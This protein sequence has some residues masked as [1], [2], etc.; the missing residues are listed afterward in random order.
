MAK[1]IFSKDEARNA[2]QAGVNKVAEPVGSTM[3]AGGKTVIISNHYNRDPMVTKD[4]V[5]VA[6]CIILP[7]LKENVG[8]R[9]MRKA[10]ES[11]AKEAGDGT[12]QTI[13]LAQS[14]INNGLELIKQGKSP[15]K[16][17]SGINKGVDCIVETLKKISIP[18]KD[19]ETIRNIATISAN[20]DKKIGDL[21]AKGYDKIGHDGIMVIENSPTS[22]TKIEVIEGVEIPRGYVSPDFVNDNAKQRVVHENPIYIIAD[23]SISNMN[24]LAPILKQLFE[25]ELLAQ[26]IIIIATDFEGEAF[27]SVLQNHRQGIVKA[28]LVKA[29]FAYR[30]EYLE[31][32]AIVTGA[33][34]I[35]DE[36]GLKME[37]MTIEHLGRSEKVIITE[38]STTIIGGL[39]DKK[40][41]DAQKNTIRVQMEAYADQNTDES[42]RLKQDW[43][44]RLGR[45]SSSI[46]IIKVGGSTD[47]ELG[48]RKDR[49]DDA[50]RA[51][52]SSIEEGI[53]LGGGVTLLMCVKE[54]NTIGTTSDDEH[55]GLSLVIKACSAPLDK[56]LD[57][58][59]LDKD[60]LD[61]LY[62]KI[63]AGEKNIGYNI[64]TQAFEDLFASGVIDPAKVIRCA[65]QNAAS[66]A[67]HAIISDY[68]LVEMPV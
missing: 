8:A 47:V 20:N 3:G 39:G 42:N 51:V 17:I 34:V 6:S 1:D 36:N 58:A 41:L 11:T 50:C 54:L 28:C 65:I 16:I 33:T 14:L 46:C 2:L 56:M 44:I 31:D 30:R 29:P 19:N 32:M 64:K 45:I 48:E 35:C 68:L 59:G 63:S 5:T 49:V 27:S 18:V 62:I 37:N 57:N 15:Q 38:S 7:N 26:P 10:A 22:E 13:V 23:Y 4:G 55:Y 67:T 25:K 52:K 43:K 9:L 12:T 60:I 61:Q 53:V 66:V 24:Q 40:K 21:I